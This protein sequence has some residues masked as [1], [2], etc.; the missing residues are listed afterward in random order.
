M[1]VKIKITVHYKLHHFHKI[2]HKNFTSSKNI[3]RK[4]LQK[5]DTKLL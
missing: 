3:P 4:V 5:F 2:V 1:N